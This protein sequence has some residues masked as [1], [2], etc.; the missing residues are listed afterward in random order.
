MQEQVRGGGEHAVRGEGGAGHIAIL[1]R[2]VVEACAPAEAS[3]TSADRRRGPQSAARYP[4]RDV[5]ARHWQGVAA[6]TSGSSA[7]APRRRLHAPAGSR[8][9]PASA[10]LRISAFWAREKARVRLVAE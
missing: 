1:V 8:S 9:E 6:A 3:A 4:R 10:N 2:P 7:D 5:P